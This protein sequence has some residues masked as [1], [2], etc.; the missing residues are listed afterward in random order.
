MT[1]DRLKILKEMDKNYIG[2]LQEHYE[3]GT[4][5]YNDLEECN[6]DI[7]YLVKE[8]KY[9]N[10]NSICLWLTNGKTYKC[11]RLDKNNFYMQYLSKEDIYKKYKQ[12]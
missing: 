6:L 3:V 10:H 4:S 11:T 2:E 1:N 9:W 8:F 7:A 12:L 5:I